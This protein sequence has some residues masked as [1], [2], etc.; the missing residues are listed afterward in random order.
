MQHMCS[1][2]LCMPGETQLLYLPPMHCCWTRQQADSAASLCRPYVFVCA[3]SFLGGVPSTQEITLA[4]MEKALEQAKTRRQ[5][6][7]REMQA[8]DPPLAKKLSKIAPRIRSSIIHKIEQVIGAGAKNISMLQATAGCN[9]ITV[10]APTLTFPP[11]ID[12]LQLYQLLHAQLSVTS[13]PQVRL[14]L[15]CSGTQQVKTVTVQRLTTWPLSWWP[16]QCSLSCLR[17][18]A[19]IKSLTSMQPWRDLH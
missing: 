4:V 8:C 1:L 9:E 13:Q 15:Q 14:Q 19:S 17:Q 10:S 11:H 12:V 16:C 18:A 2:H 7:L 5:Q 3:T 6:I